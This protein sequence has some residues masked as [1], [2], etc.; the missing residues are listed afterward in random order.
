MQEN[1][2]PSS[3]P[4]NISPQLPED[5]F[6][7]TGPRRVL[8]VGERKFTP[9]KYY[10]NIRFLIDAYYDI[11][12]CRIADLLRVKGLKR[13]HGIDQ[14]RVRELHERTDEKL[15]EIEKG[16]YKE[17]KSELRQSDIWREWLSGIKGV[18]PA[19]G[20]GII[21]WIADPARY[22]YTAN[23]WSDCG[24]AVRDGKAVRRVKCEKLHH[25]PKLKVMCFKLG[26]MFVRVGGYYREVYSTY[27][28]HYD[29]KYVG[30]FGK[31]STVHNYTVD[32][33]QKLNIVDPQAEFKDGLPK[34]LSENKEFMEFWAGVVSGKTLIR[35]TGEAGVLELACTDGHRFMMA[36]RA[37][38]KLFLS[39]L[40]EVWKKLQNLPHERPFAIAMMGHDANSYIAPPGREKK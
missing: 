25:N 27:R 30:T 12:Q 5:D 34:E 13:V 31:C 33:L 2:N 28:G 8:D 21:A 19:L 17:I 22:K 4:E 39:H 16:I 9:P 35:P 15:F 32:A 11:Q 24:L 40:L 37:T 26:D 18:G 10:S 3:E 6:D 14:E 7:E 1:I 38:V 29:R 36:K 23:L 20:G